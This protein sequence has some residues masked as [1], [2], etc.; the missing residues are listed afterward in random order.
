LGVKCMVLQCVAVCWVYKWCIV[1]SMVGESMA[2]VYDDQ[3]PLA[4]N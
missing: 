1:E 3:T 4:K 2:G